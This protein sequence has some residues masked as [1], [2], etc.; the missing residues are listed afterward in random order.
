MLR[1]TATYTHN[2]NQCYGVIDNCSPND[3]LARANSTTDQH[4][5]QLARPGCTVA[6]T[7][8]KSLW[9]VTRGGEG[10]GGGGDTA[11]PLPPQ[12]MH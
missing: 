4:L 12:V 6:A 1:I 10:E 2:F 9:E 8:V 5:T 11:T 7:H 3:K